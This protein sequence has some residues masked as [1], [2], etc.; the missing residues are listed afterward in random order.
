MSKKSAKIAATYFVTIIFSLLL[1]GGAGYFILTR[2]M[3]DDNDNNKI[4]PAQTA[5]PVTSADEYEPTAADSQTLLF[6]YEEEKKLSSS[7]FVLA[8]FIPAE[9]KVAIAPLQSDTCLTVD[10][11]TN[12]LYEFYRLGGSADAVKAVESTFKINIDKYMVMSSE[13]FTTFSNFMGNISYDVPYNLIYEDTATGDTTIVKSGTQTL[14]SVTLKKVLTFPE[15]K[16][17]E[18]ERAR[19]VGT[20]VTEL[21]NS[22]ADGILRDGMDAVFNDIINSDIETDITRYDYD[23]SKTAISYVIDNSSSPAQLVLPSGTYNDNGCYVPDESF[24]SVLPKLF[25]IE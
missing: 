21:I 24:I 12:T 25:S 7:C 20:I 17:G 8:R 2:F 10:G 18:E 1:I 9:S 19:V 3:L 14:D 13:S 16:S 22:G 11:S 6:I 23:E 5:A 15:Y 4:T